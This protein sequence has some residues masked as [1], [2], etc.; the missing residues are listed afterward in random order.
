MVNEG[1]LGVLIPGDIINTV[2]SIVVPAKKPVEIGKGSEERGEKRR[3]RGG[4]EEGRG[5][6]EERWEERRRGS[7][8]W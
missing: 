4:G 8:N 3:K 7:T 5:G 2:G 6:R 1:T